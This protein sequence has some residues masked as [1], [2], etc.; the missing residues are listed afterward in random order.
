MV[1][2]VINI[3]GIQLDSLKAAG[4]EAAA[5]PLPANNSVVEITV[6]DKSENNYRLLIEGSVFQAKLPVNVNTGEALIARVINTNPFT[7]SLDN[8]VAAKNLGGNVV[9]YII[10]KLHLM[11][12]E[13]SNKVVKAF[14]SG[15]KPLV[16]SKLNKVIDLLEK[17]NIKLDD[18][19]LNFF[20]QVLHTDE[21]SNEF[22]NRSVA[23]LCQHSIGSLTD[24]I[25]QIVRKINSLN[26][27]EELKAK[28]NET[29]VLDIT[30]AKN[31]DPISIKKKA[32]QSEKYAGILGMEEHNS[33]NA[34]D[35][36][37][38]DLKQILIRYNL[39]RS[40]YNKTGIY[41]GFVIL[42]NE[43]A[44]D[45]FEFEF[46][47]RDQSH[48]AHSHKLEFSMSPEMLGTVEV[49]GFMAGINLNAV[50]SAERSALN[51]LEENKQQLISGLGSRNLIPRIYFEELLQGQKR[52]AVQDGRQ[53][54]N[55]RL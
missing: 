36:D 29:L 7:L 49:D 30:D 51:D 52:Q 22:I 46:E 4:T 25:Y 6:L 3:T 37:L 32:A 50:V 40:C 14:I 41:P 26:G 44:L 9:S 19:Q 15:K 38:E 53:S 55:V 17:E 24:E 31:I 21:R 18:Q 16:K 8:L 1:P 10:S 43:Q 39:L 45:L 13:T 47:K 12:T 34:N 33:G 5:K 11:D 48:E 20:I 23:V 28:V 35:K 2:Q 54:I 27:S 42:K